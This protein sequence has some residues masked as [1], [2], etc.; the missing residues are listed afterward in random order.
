MIAGRSILIKFRRFVTMLGTENL[1]QLQKLFKSANGESDSEDDDAGIVGG[2]QQL[3]ETLIR[4]KKFVIR[5][6]NEE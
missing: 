1:K 5:T 4:C 3:G 6:C 2:A